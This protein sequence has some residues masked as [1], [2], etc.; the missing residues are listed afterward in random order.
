MVGVGMTEPPADLNLTP[1]EE[2]NMRNFWIWCFGDT[3]VDWLFLKALR[4]DL[5][6]EAKVRGWDA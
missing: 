1:E 3:P 4:D 2:T 5:R 6:E